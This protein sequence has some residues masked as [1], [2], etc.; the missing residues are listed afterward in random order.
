M[1]PLWVFSGNRLVRVRARVCACERV[2]AGARKSFETPTNG[3]SGCL[4][5][6]KGRLTRDDG[7]WRLFHF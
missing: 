6:W 2:R 4:A 7:V 3:T 1:F 5:R